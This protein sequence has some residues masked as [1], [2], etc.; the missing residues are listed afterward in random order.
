M[1][2]QYAVK[3]GDIYILEVNPR[4]SRTIP[5]VSK[6]TGIPFAR[7]AT[8]VICGQ[9]LAAQHLAGEVEMPYV[10]IKE[11]VFPFNKFPGVDVILGPE[12]KST[13]EV[14]GIDEDFGLAYAKAQ[15]ASNNRIPTAGRIF[16]SV[17]D[18]DKGP[19]LAAM[20]ARL[21]AMGMGIVAT[22]GTARYLEE[23]GIIVD[24]INKVGEG[25]PH[26]VDMIKNR[27]VDF[28][29][30]TVAGEQAQQD[31]LAIR[32][33]A[34]QYRVPYTTTFAGAQAVVAAMER[35]KEKEIQIKSIQEY[36]AVLKR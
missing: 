16:I 12:M 33:S 18:R 32:R 24:V 17:K 15:A 13:G 8:R 35:I 5:F 3:N 9:S 30:N 19:A 36:H 29:I 23:Q 27:E 22:R 21:Q 31:S 11:A 6:A 34:L 26:V 1:N 20:A 2:V 14:M 28:I 7:L 10:A 25:R 4:A